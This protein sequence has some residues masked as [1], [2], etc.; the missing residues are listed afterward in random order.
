MKD[1]KSHYGPWALIT[2]ASSGI[3]EEFA[4]QLAAAGLDLI[5]VA[6]RQ[7]RLEALAEE[8]GQAYGV[9]TRTVRADLSSTTAVADIAD[10][11]DDL[12]VGLLVSNAGSAGGVG[13]FLKG[14]D[15]IEA[16][17][18]QLNAIAPMRLAYHFG[19]RMRTRGRGGILFT[20]STSAFQPTPYLA[21]YAASKAYLLSLG[22][23]LN[24]ELKDHSVDVTVLVPGAT[25]TAVVK[26]FEGVDMSKVRMPLDGGSAGSAGRFGWSR[27]PRLRGPRRHEQG[28]AFPRQAG[29]EQPADGVGIRRPDAARH[30]SR[31]PLGNWHSLEIGEHKARLIV[32]R[33]PQIIHRCRVGVAR[34]GIVIRLDGGGLLSDGVVHE[35]K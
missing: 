12:E 32:D 30:S 21:N 29:V 4:H 5:L 27:P 25:K 6:R 16:D 17:I 26:W 9:A 8:L 2:G 7:E 13:S 22:E 11:T 14:D 33:V 10:A 24:L 34:H 1:L 28:H 19:N 18:V 23:A 15:A 20:S 3:G 35:S 31:A